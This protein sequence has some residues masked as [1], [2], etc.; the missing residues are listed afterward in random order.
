MKDKRNK[1]V[2]LR[3]DETRQSVPIVSASGRGLIAEDIIA[4][5]KENNIP[6]MEDPSL[7]ALLA[8]LNINEAI[9]EELYEAVAEVFAFIY[10]A[11]QEINKNR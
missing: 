10:R 11:D 7:V 3:Y 4:K 6:I 9:P 8:Q 2:A 5:A 1:A